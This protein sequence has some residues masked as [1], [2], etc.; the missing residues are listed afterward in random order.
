MSFGHRLEI[1]PHQKARPSSFFRAA[2]YIFELADYTYPWPLIFWRHNGQRSRIVTLQSIVLSYYQ[3]TVYSGSSPSQTDFSLHPCTPNLG[4]APGVGGTRVRV[5][6]T[7]SMDPGSTLEMNMAVS[8]DWT[9][10]AWTPGVAFGYAL[11]RR[12]ARRMLNPPVVSGAANSGGDELLRGEGGYTLR[13]SE[14][15]C[16]VANGLG[17]TGGSGLVVSCEWEEFSE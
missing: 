12:I 2:T 10:A 16:L 15:L 14:W 8:A 4:N 3:R 11:D 7:H 9:A 1:P 17:A 13:Q 5:S 6:P